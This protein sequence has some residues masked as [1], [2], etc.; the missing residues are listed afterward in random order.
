M[1]HLKSFIDMNENE[2]AIIMLKSHKN[3]ASEPIQ[4]EIKKR[5]KRIN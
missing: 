1:P 5:F 2:R 3:S 4:N